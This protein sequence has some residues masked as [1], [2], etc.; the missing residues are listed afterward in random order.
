MRRRS[1][2]SRAR[3][4]LCRLARERLR[5]AEA[6]AQLLARFPPYEKYLKRLTTDRGVWLYEIMGWPDGA[7]RRGA[8]CQLDGS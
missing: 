3:R 2:S 4:A 8:P 6:Q 1:R 7:G 5:A